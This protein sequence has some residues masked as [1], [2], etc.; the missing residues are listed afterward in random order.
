[1]LEPIRFNLQCIRVDL[2][3]P[4]PP[5]RTKLDIVRIN[6]RNTPQRLEKRFAG[7]TVLD[8]KSNIG[9]PVINAVNRRGYR[10]RFQIVWIL[11]AGIKKM[12]I[13]ALD[14]KT[15]GQFVKAVDDLDYGCINPGI[16]ES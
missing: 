4:K 2:S 11:L 12:S 8:A 10:Q 9:D 6:Q 3:F 1:M 14:G 5:C 15:M 13:A 16:D 7:R